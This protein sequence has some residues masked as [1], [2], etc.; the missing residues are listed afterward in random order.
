MYNHPHPGEII[1]E[2]VLQVEG[3]NVAD[4]ARQLGIFEK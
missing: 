3:I 1:K 2:D 4:A